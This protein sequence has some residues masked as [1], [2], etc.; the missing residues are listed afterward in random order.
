MFNPYLPYPVTISDIRV[1]TED[2]TLRTF[3]LSFVHEKDAEAFSYQPG[4]FAELSVP[5]AG[6][7]PIGIASS[8]TEGDKL[9]FTVFKAGTVTSRLHTMQ[10]GDTMGVRGPLG[11]YYPLNEH[12]G[13]NIVIIAGGY[14]VTTLRSTMIWLLHEENRHRFGDIT[15][16]YGA[17]TPGMLLF[18]D[19]LEAWRARTDIHCHITVDT[20][21]EDWSGHVG[22]V[23]TITGEV[24]PKPE[25]AIALVCGP[26]IMIKFTQPVLDSLGWKDDQI[27][28]S[29]ENRMKCGIGICGRCNVGHKYVCKDG[30]VFSKQELGDLPAEY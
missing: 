15:F 28:L 24:A 12:E 19:E 7:S 1:E 18:K 8:P 3:E 21:Q 25:N 27:F 29:L 30:P 5:G 10:V 23:P 17:R 26:P 13:K 20:D 14:A 16:I 11:N 9:L 2:K 6:E 22:F 4:Q